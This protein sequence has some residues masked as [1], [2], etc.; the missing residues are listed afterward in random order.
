MEDYGRP[1]RQALPALDHGRGD[2]RHDDRTVG[3]VTDRSIDVQTL[4]RD[5]GRY[6][7]IDVRYPNEWEAGHIE[8]AAHIQL[9]YVFDHADE[10]D[11]NRPVVTVCRSGN[12]SVEAAKDFAREGFDVRSLSG[13]IEAWV[14]HGL[15]IVAADGGRGRIV[16]GEPPPDDRPAEMQQFQ[17]DFMEA[18]FA[19]HE[20]F[21]DREPSEEEVLAFLRQRDE[22]K[23]PS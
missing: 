2:E 18:I 22:Q 11:R 8:G 5:I 9:D 6:Q 19:V 7:V 1:G 15:P 12:R 23:P 17:N 10:L 21:G 3:A 13:G 14:G 20:H 4:A 16:D